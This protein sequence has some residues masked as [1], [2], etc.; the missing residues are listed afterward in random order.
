MS[1]R[2]AERVPSAALASRLR[3]PGW[4]IVTTLLA[5]AAVLAVEV[6]V[7]AAN[8]SVTSALWALSVARML[9]LPVAPM[10]VVVFIMFLWSLRKLAR[11]LAG[12]GQGGR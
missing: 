2:L 4:L 1:S 7:R 8:P 6:I 5:V 10:L 3:V 9:L 11:M 12:R